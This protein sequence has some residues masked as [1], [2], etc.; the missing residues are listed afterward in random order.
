[1]KRGFSIVEL[2]VTI[3]II[4]IVLGA[5]TFGI[6]NAVQRRQAAAF[7]NTLSTMIGSLPSLASSKGESV[8]VG[9]SDNKV[10]VALSTISTPPAATS[11]P[12]PALVTIDTS[13]SVLAIADPTG[14]V[15]APEN[16]LHLVVNGKD[17]YLTITLSGDVVVDDTGG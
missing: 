12:V 10:F 3:A 4:I 9:Y 17:L 1:M 11:V 2:I 14:A 7:P 8:K 5:T 13:S 16:P 6:A 15:T